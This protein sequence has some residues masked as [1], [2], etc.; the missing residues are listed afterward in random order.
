V[1]RLLLP[2]AL[3]LVAAGCLG[4]AVPQ[5]EGPAP[6]AQT[7]L[8]GLRPIE[9]SFSGTATGNPAAPYAQA[10]TFDVP[11][12]A[13]GI[14]ATLAWSDPVARFTLELVDPYGDIVETG[15]PEQDG[16]LRV[17]TLEPPASGTWTLRVGSILSVNVPF[18]LDAVT[19]LLVPQHNV[20]RTSAQMNAGTFREV[21][22]I[23]EKDATFN[24]TFEASAPVN[25]D[26]HSHPPGGVKYWQEGTDASFTGS[27]TAPERGIYSLLFENANALPVDITYE[28]TGAF[29]LHSH[30][31]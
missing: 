3:A 2:L 24:F 22:V 9:T 15:Y 1:P 14:N 25:W 21:N 26:V 23:M 27:F 12:G 11:Q 10:F 4:D 20:V 17:A 13:V 29:R 7:D 30:A 16:V 8:A 18:T 19:E 6:D 31:Q 5:E 28:M